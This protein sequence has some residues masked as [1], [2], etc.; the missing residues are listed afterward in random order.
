MY[1]S[2]SSN[3]PLPTLAW[4]WWGE[5]GIGTA[6]NFIEVQVYVSLH[7]WRKYSS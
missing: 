1:V 3:N 5:T 7:P 4:E 6:D 2:I